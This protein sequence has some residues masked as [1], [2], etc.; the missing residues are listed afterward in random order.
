MTKITATPESIG[1]LIRESI[2]NKGQTTFNCKHIEGE[3]KNEHYGLIEIEL[4]EYNGVYPT[5]VEQHG[6]IKEE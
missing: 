2:L 3:G 4:N 5:W 1:Y 6:V